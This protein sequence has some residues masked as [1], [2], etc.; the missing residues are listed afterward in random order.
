MSTLALFLMLQTQ[1]VLDTDYC[2][3]VACTEETD[4]CCDETVQS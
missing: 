3:D 2:Q 4:T 1:P